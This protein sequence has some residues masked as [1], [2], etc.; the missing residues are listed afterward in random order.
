[1]EKMRKKENCVLPETGKIFTLNFDAKFRQLVVNR[2]RTSKSRF[3]KPPLKLERNDHSTHHLICLWASN[4]NAWSG[5]NKA[6]L[7]PY[8]EWE[9]ESGDSIQQRSWSLCEYPWWL[10]QWLARWRPSFSR[11]HRWR[12]SECERLRS[13]KESCSKFD[14]WWLRQFQVSHWHKDRCIFQG[15]GGDASPEILRT[16]TSVWEDAYARSFAG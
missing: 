1:M 9:I 14:R 4:S 2:L 5:T 13:R 10:I 7:D 8:G 3:S 16:D 6:G 15:V 12:C 11:T